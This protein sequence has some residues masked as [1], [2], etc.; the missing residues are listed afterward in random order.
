MMSRGSQTGNNGWR[1][2]T[3]VEVRDVSDKG[4]YEVVDV[5][6]NNNCREWEVVPTPGESGSDL[7]EEEIFD[8]G[9]EP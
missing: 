4:P 9:L 5:F 6:V 3:I 1:E 2:A 8:P 7:G